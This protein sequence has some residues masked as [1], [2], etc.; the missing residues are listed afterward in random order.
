[1]TNDEMELKLKAFEKVLKIVTL[2][3]SHVESL[4]VSKDELEQAVL[5]LQREVLLI[6]NRL[7]DLESK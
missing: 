5:A 1:M 6:R 3:A 4:V 2:Q 7:D